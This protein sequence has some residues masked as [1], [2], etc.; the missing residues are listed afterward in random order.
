MDN[1]IK[2]FDIEY[3]P[4]KSDR[5]RVNAGPQHP[6]THGVLRLEVEVEGE[7]VTDVVPHLGYLHRCFEKT[8]ENMT[9]NQIVPYTDRL[10]YV[11]SMNNELPFVLAVEK[12]A[13]IEVNE[14]V[15]FVRVMAAEINRIANHFLAISTFG[16]D[17]GAFTPL[18]YLFREREYALSILEKLSGARLL[19]NYMC[20]GGV[21]YEVY[22]YFKKDVKEFIARTRK[23]TKIEAEDLLVFNKI[24]IERTVNVGILTK[25]VATN[26][27]CSGPLGRGSGIN[28]D[29]RKSNP[30]SGYEKFDFDVPVIEKGK[31]VLG[32]QG[33][34]WNRNWV[35]IKEIEESCKIL[36]QALEMMPD[37]G[38]VTEGI[39]KKLKMPKGET[40]FKCESPKGE[41]GFY[42][43]SNG[44]DKPER[45][46]CRSTS[47]INLAVLPEMSRGYLFADLIMILGGIDIVLGEVDR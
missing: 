11:S 32:V 4:V 43:V 42:I 1:N 20:P 30:Y 5:M 29:V 18:L 3:S 21:R 28:Y 19:Y 45:C 13:G 8:C 27:A 38:S 10:D 9:Y 25:E 16:L 37:D 12:L 33:D 26:Y 17:S 2:K 7:I 15:Q 14:K 24:F 39:P 47:F 46:H 6:S 23:Y 35:R 44:T 41:L 36:E 22:P 40:Y 34:C 31:E